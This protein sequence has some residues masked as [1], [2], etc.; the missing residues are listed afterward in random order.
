[1]QIIPG[2]PEGKR[3][4]VMLSD[5]KIGVIKSHTREKERQTGEEKRKDAFPELAG[6]VFK[7]CFGYKGH[8]PEKK[9]KPYQYLGD[10]ACHSI[11]IPSRGQPLHKGFVLQFSFASLT[12]NA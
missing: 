2:L 9:H 6:S 5:Q 4:L 7:I 12:N 1:M 11:H 8:G 3:E 10:N